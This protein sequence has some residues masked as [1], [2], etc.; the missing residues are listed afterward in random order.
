MSLTPLFAALL[1]LLVT[2]LAVNVSML[3][4]RLKISLG[5][6]GDKTM[7]KAIRAHANALEHSLPF[8]LLLLFREQQVGC[9]RGLTAI[10]ITFVVARVL[11]AAGMLGGPFILRRVGAS[12]TLV[13]E[14]WLAL[15]LLRTAIG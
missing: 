3:R 12:V 8:I 4:M 2:L 15:A 6:G 1:L 9:A 13:L 5:D 11:H 14:L 7:N 10:A